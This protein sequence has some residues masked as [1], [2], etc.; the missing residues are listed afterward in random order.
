MC[1]PLSYASGFRQTT[2]LLILG[3]L[4]D[5][6]SV[7]VPSAPDTIAVTIP[8][9]SASPLLAEFT[10]VDESQANM[11]TQAPTKSSAVERPLDRLLKAVSIL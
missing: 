4:P 1:R 2:L 10:S 7:N 8:G 11:P 5:W 9:I 6:T 3:R